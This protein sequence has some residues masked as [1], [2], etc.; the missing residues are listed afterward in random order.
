MSTANTDFSGELHV[1]LWTPLVQAHGATVNVGRDLQPPRGWG[2]VG[3]P[4]TAEILRIPE[5]AATP[6]PDQA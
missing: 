4:I 2:H 3:G 6:A 5:E 1:P